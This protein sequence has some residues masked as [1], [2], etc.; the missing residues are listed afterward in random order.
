M[1]GH[2]R[3]QWGKFKPGPIPDTTPPSVPTGLTLVLATDSTV[4]LSWSAST[5]TGGSG[6]KGYTIHRAT[7]EL[8]FYASIGTS[9]APLTSFTDTGRNYSTPYWYKVSAFDNAGNNSAL[10]SSLVVTTGADV[11]APTIPQNLHVTGFTANSISLAWNASTDI[12]GSGV[13]GY[14]VYRSL[15][16]GGTYSLVENITSGTSCTNLGLSLSTTYWYKIAA[17]DVAG[18][19]SAYSTEVFQTTSSAI[20]GWT[21]PEGIDQSLPGP[22][23][24]G[25]EDLI[26]LSAYSYTVGG[27]P[28]YTISEQRKDGS[29]GVYGFTLDALSGELTKPAALPLGDYEVDVNLVDTNATEI[30][31]LFL[32]GAGP[33]TF[34]QVFPDD[35]TGSE[36]GG[37]VTVA[38]GQGEVRNRWPSGRVKFAVLSGISGGSGDV[39][40]VTSLTNTMVGSPVVEPLSLTATVDCGTLGTASLAEAISG[41][42]LTW[43]LATPRRST[44]HKVRE[45]LGPVMSEFH[46]YSPLQGGTDT[47]MG[48]WW[49]VRAYLGG[50][51]EVET[52]VENGWTMVASPTQKAYTV[53]VNVG[54]S[55]NPR[56]SGAV[57]QYHHTRWSRSDWVGTDPGILPAHE[58]AYLRATKLV[59]NYGPAVPT[60]QAWVTPGGVPNTWGTPCNN[61]NPDPLAV[62]DFPPG[63]E[64]MGTEGYHDSIG[65]MM[66]LDTLYI[67]SQNPVAY[68]S[69]IGSA[70]S[71][72]RYSTHQRDET[73]GRPF[74]VSQPLGIPAY[75]TQLGFTGSSDAGTKYGIY[76]GSVTLPSPLDLSHW[77]YTSTHSPAPPYLAYLITGRWV[78][79]EECQLHANFNWLTDPVYRDGANGVLQWASTSYQMR[80]AAWSWRTA[81]MAACVTPDASTGLDGGLKAEYVGILAGNA[82]YYYDNYVVGAYQNGLHALAEYGTSTETRPWMTGFGVAVVG[83]VSDLGL[84]TGTAAIKHDLFRDWFYHFVTGRMQTTYGPTGY[85]WHEAPQYS[86]LYEPVGQAHSPQNYFASWGEAYVANGYPSSCSTSGDPPEVAADPKGTIVAGYWGNLIPALSY[87]KDHVGSTAFDLLAQAPTYQNCVAGS[88]GGV[89]YGGFNN[90]PIWYVVPR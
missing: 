56:Y 7:S 33:W 67:C 31:T 72:G 46:Y 60:S 69:V 38:G 18:N 21:I 30:T 87:A 58:G 73:T 43:S 55:G 24:V 88:G 62:A 1:S 65:L 47:Y 40:I 29:I 76:A 78:F 37:Y 32:S 23:F 84:L 35:A 48:V 74:R 90:N 42:L 39:S 19:I 66:R 15:L 27:T 64:G 89:T 36:I 28:S 54:S 52:V 77:Q 70:R 13:A 50:A 82:N 4:S 53:T 2:T 17:Y 26:E 12:N 16:Q 83:F 14:Y 11:T 25:E 9:L 44:P 61:V 6:L 59:P 22:F 57:A 34:G 86:M 51:I 8:G 49:Y 3:H 5:D 20:F 71:W 45:I 10:S 41:G 85:C 79:M 68:R 81:A 75:A 63:A 80:G